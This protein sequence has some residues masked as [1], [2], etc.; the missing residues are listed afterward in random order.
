MDF[1]YYKVKIIA[2]FSWY[3]IGGWVGYLF[4][5]FFFS[6]TPFLKNPFSKRQN[7]DYVLTILAGGLACWMIFS[8]LDNYLIDP[9]APIYLT[10]S[11]AASIFWAVISSEMYKKIVRA[12]FNTWVVFV[13]WLV[14]W[15]IVGRIGAFLIG[16]RDH[17]HWTPTSLPWGIDYGDGIARHP[18]QIYEI[19]TLT[20]FFIIFCFLLKYKKDWILKNGFFLFT[21]VYFVYRFLVGFIS[22]YSHFWLWLNTYQVISIGMIWYSI[23]KIKKYF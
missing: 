8:T 12:K 4:Y 15:M 19:L 20:I 2:D 16:L 17:T 3:I 18:L 5:R 21:L 1:D 9:T 13:P 6:H 22:P 14:T 23:Y 7:F 10:K 11:I